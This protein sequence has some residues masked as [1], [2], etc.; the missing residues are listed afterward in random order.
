MRREALFSKN[1]YYRFLLDCNVLM[2]REAVAAATAVLRQAQ[3]RWPS[4]RPAKVLDLA[5]GGLPIAISE[6]MANLAPRA[7][8]YTGVDINPDQVELAGRFFEFPANVVRVRLIEGS[9]WDM[10]DLALE[11]PYDLIFSGMNLHHGTPPELVF[12]ARQLEGLLAADGLFISHDVYRPEA[13]VYRPRPACNPQ[14]PCESFRLVDPQ[15]LA[16]AQVD[17]PVFEED[18]GE[19]EPAWREDYLARM[20][21]AL[22]E[23]GGQGEGARTTV[24]HMRQRDYPVSTAELADCFAPAGLAL[25]ALRFTGSDEP[26]APFIA[27]AVASRRSAGDPT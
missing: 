25:R 24:A 17:A 6:V 21:R 12:L 14:D 2:H 26:L 23:R 18:R 5:C 4:D 10:R 3:A 9:A 13:E 20:H 8:H 22:L 19:A 1:G 27:M 11:P 15:R 16:E 7:F